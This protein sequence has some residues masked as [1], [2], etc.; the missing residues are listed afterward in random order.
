MYAKVEEVEVNQEQ[1][2]VIFDKTGKGT[3]RIH[4]LK[5]DPLTFHQQECDHLANKMLQGVRDFALTAEG[6]LVYISGG[7][8]INTGKSINDLIV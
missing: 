3:A 6:N 2:V 4:R 5:T 8:D 1:R 7:F